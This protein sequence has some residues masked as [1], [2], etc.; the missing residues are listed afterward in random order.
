MSAAPLELLL[1]G[2]VLSAAGAE[3]LIHEV[4]TGRM[5][6]ASLGAALAAWRLRGAQADEIA[7]AARAMRAHMIPVVSARADQ[8][9]D[10][11]GTGGDGSGSFNI[12]TAAALVT[13]ACGVPVAK[14]G[15]RAASSRCGS[16]DVLA[17]LGVHLDVNP[18]A[19][20]RVLDEVG[21][22]FLFAPNHHPAMRHAMPVRRE[23]GM[24]TIFNVLGPLTN[25]AGVLHQLLGV[26]SPELGP[27]LA[28]ALQ[29]LGSRRAWIVHGHGGLDEVALTGPTR[30]TEL[31]D[32]RITE[33][34]LRP[35]SL[36]LELCG[37]AALD[38]GDAAQNARL[39]RAVLDGE[40]GPRTDA[41]LL[42][43]A[44]ALVVAGA[45]P[46]ADAGLDRARE[47]IGSGRAARLLADLVAATND[48]RDSNG[49][50][51]EQEGFRPTA[52]ARS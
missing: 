42:N 6:P 36:G 40:P 14:H 13:A 12:S 31:A 2:E 34:T 46:D 39:L 37:R 49:T 27:V 3:T 17:E 29:R 33:Q 19:L 26:Y 18:A 23:L 11:C 44:C 50:D 52:E 47:A 9:I 28:G 21:I 16:A 22:A 1:A 51:D 30:I 41:T 5:G 38:G 10:T 48:L 20:G 24:R 15:N 4:M 43:T 32:G 8:A 45:A 25:P 35:E 7:G